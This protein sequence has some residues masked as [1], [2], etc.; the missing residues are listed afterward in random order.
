MKNSGSKNEP[1]Q[2][3]NSTVPEN[4]F[5]SANPV[6]AAIAKGSPGQEIKF[7]LWV[8]ERSW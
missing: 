1:S 8:A 7:A 6:A 4:E 2:D 3:N 5:G